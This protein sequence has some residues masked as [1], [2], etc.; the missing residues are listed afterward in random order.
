MV[1]ISITFHVSD[2]NYALIAVIK[3]T[4]PPLPPPLPPETKIPRPPSCYVSF[5]KMYVD[6][7]SSLYGKRHVTIRR[8]LASKFHASPLLIL[9]V[10]GY[11]T[12]KGSGASSS[13]TSNTEEIHGGLF[14]S[15]L[16]YLNRTGKVN[17]R[18]GGDRQAIVVVVALT[19]G[20]LL[21]R[22]CWHSLSL[23]SVSTPLFFLHYKVFGLKSLILSCYYFNFRF[24]PQISPRQ[25]LRSG[26][27]IILCYCS[28][29][30]RLSH[31]FLNAAPILIFAC[32]M[33]PFFFSL[34]S[35]FITILV[36]VVEVWA[37]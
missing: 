31:S 35:L 25:P 9:S 23:L 27:S 17:T 20:G 24:C 26:L 4:P 13:D 15:F 8:P 33:P 28:W 16:V 1:N 11:N 29:I 10:W 30:A 3:R 37:G 36:V 14:R 2:L 5:Y 7:R 21:F 18:D 19:R 34:L 12:L 6:R 32:C 22:H